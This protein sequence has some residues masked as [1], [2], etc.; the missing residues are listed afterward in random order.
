LFEAL[1][2]DPTRGDVLQWVTSYDT[3]WTS[4]GVPLVDFKALGKSGA[5]PRM[6]FSWYSGEYCSDPDFANLE[7]ELRANPSMAS[8][9]EGR[10][11]LEQQRRRLPAHKYRR[12]H[13]NIGGA[14]NGAYLDQAVVESAIVK[15]RTCLPPE[16]GR[17]YH[18]WVDMSGG[19]NDEATLGVAHEEHGKAVL[20]LLIAQD[21]APPF[22]P[23][24]AV[25]KFAV[26][27]KR[28]GIRTVHGD[29]Y[30]GQTFRVDFSECGIDYVVCRGRV[31]SKLREADTSEA[32]AVHRT[33]LY[34]ALEPTLNAGEVELLDLPKLKEQLLTLVVRGSSI[35]HEPG[36]HDDWANAAAGA[37]YL[38]NSNRAGNSAEHWI[39]FYAEMPAR[40]VA[41]EAAAAA[42]PPL[43]PSSLEFGYSIA[44]RPAG[45]VTVKV[46]GEISSI[47]GMSGTTYMTTIVDGVRVAHLG[48]ED[49]KALIVGSSA[50]REANPD[51]VAQ[52]SRV[53]PPRPGIRVGDV[54]QAAADAG[55]PDPRGVGSMALNSLRAICTLRE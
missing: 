8:W 40:E 32:P 25:A 53:G 24:L 3:I 49:A 35:D 31:G 30:A 39:R 38:C 11:Y 45:Y 28:Y 13:L 48:A 52:L 37:L 36:G 27:L 47:V 41:K 23:R 19:S 34:E 50:F 21:G 7:P 12:L 14:V 18:A 54:L 44:P 46:P 43:A 10:G 16:V 33:D 29:A 22:N 55:P 42:S 2:P 20:D 17:Q 4:P 6:Y 26:V 1:A 51:L 15:G 9:P 5:D